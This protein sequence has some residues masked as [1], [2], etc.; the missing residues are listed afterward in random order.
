ML[1]APA[2]D[3]HTSTNAGTVSPVPDPESDRLRFSLCSPWA[4]TCPSGASSSS[5]MPCPYPAPPA[6]IRAA[7]RKA[8]QQVVAIGAGSRATAHFQ[9]RCDIVRARNRATAHVQVRNGNQAP[10]NR[11]TA[12]FQDRDGYDPDTEPRHGALLGPQA[13]TATSPGLPGKWR[14]HSSRSRGT[15]IPA[16][17]M[18][19]LILARVFPG[20]E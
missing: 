14:R 18:A 8:G 11:A 20:V 15:G 1:S 10:R 5:R 16:R 2:V 4:D 17:P 7:R 19:R 12:H 13:G 6:A 9:V 3:G